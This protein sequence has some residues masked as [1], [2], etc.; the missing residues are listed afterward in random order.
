MNAVRTPG[1]RK[2]FRPRQQQ[3][4]PPPPHDTAHPLEQGS[5]FHREQTVM[6]EHDTRPSWQALQR[7]PQRVAHTLVGHQEQAR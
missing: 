3:H 6:P 2:P 5:P 1:T 7:I 4:K